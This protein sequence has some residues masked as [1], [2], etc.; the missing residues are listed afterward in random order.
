M[1]IP[2]IILYTALAI[3]MGPI[4]N[5]SVHPA[6]EDFESKVSA[7]EPSSPREA[8]FK[9]GSGSKRLASR[10]AS[11]TASSVVKKRAASSFQT[12]R[13]HPISQMV[14]TASIVGLMSAVF[15]FLQSLLPVSDLKIVQQVGGN[16]GL[17]KMR[18]CI[19]EASP[20]MYLFLLC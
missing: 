11:R 17:G 1:R 19:D 6:P 14:F 16:G 5:N 10:A 8:G 7:S 20:L 12:A 13:K 18:E 3:I 2:V 9:M 4:P 15:V